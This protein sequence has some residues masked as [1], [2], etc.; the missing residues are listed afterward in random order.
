MKAH[1]SRVPGKNFKSIQGK[2]LYRW[3][4]DT[5]L[6]LE[7]VDQ[8]VVNTD[9]R[10]ELLDS[11]FP[12]GDRCVIKTRPDH[13]KGDDVS[14]NLILA[15]DLASHS[16]QHYLMTHTT[17]PILSKETLQDAFSAYCRGLEVGKDSLFG[18]N[19]FQT[20][21]YTEAGMPIN[22]DPEN[23]IP[24]QDLEPW[25]E[26]NSCYY[27]F[28]YE[29]FTGTRARIGRAPVMHETPSLENTDIDEWRDWHLAEAIL[30]MTLNHD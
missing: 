17:N 8:I 19:R 7:F 20:R 13:L 3:I 23:L 15:D 30:G 1:S 26:E 2:P 12:E 11:G 21:F 29:S 18:V 16:A 22:H 6:G 5:L 9:A 4:L 14:M 10:S 27:F 25:F 24:T 28:S